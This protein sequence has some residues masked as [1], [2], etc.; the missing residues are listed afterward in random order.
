MYPATPYS[1]YRW[2]N[3]SASASN[4]FITNPDGFQ[5]LDPSGNVLGT[6]DAHRSYKAAMFVLTK[7]YSHRWH[8]QVSYVWSE[9]TGTINN[10]SEGTYGVG[11]F[12]ASPTM[13]LVNAEGSLSNDRTNEIKAMLGWRIPKIE[14]SLNGYFRSISG[15]TYAPYVQLSG[16]ATNYSAT[17]YFFASSAGRRPSL[18]P[19]GNQRLP[20]VNILDLR[21]EKIFT[22][23]KDHKISVYADIFNALNNDTITSVFNNVGGTSVFNPPPAAVGST[24]VVPY[25]GP[26]SVTA[27]RQIQ[28]G[29][30]W[31]F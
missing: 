25:N 19:R 13:S 31:T 5:Y 15:G 24:T 4:L 14:L 26:A 2:A 17:G 22:V 29:A 27:P 11:S 6:V 20:T 8:G 9:S 18:E 16:S 3:R 7:N 1:Y 30:R 28:I 12:Y 23:A 10:G 21:A